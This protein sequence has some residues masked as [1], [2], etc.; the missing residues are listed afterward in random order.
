MEVRVRVRNPLGLVEF[1]VRVRA[2]V[3]TSL[4]AL[5]LVDVRVRSQ[6]EETDL[7]QQGPVG[8]IERIYTLVS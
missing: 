2:R 5:G 8:L 6:D 1:R 3:K 7:K 4:K